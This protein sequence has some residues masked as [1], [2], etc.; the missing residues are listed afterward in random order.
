MAPGLTFHGLRH[1]V[2]RLVM[3]AGGSKTDV[4][5]MIGDRS[6]VMAALYS[7]QHEKKQPVAS[8]MR[9]LKRIERKKLENPK[10]KTGKL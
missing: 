3:E 6:E 10:S 4:G 5:M 8:T 7:Q 2:G 9:R 1:T